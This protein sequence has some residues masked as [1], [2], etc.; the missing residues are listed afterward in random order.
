MMH[1]IRLGLTFPAHSLLIKDVN[2]YLSCISFN[3]VLRK[4]L[5]RISQC[6]TKVKNESFEIERDLLK[7]GNARAHAQG[8]KEVIE[9]LEKNGINDFIEYLPSRFLRRTSIASPG[10]VI[11][12]SAAKS[13]CDMIVDDLKANATFIAEM[14]PALGKL[15]KCLID[16]GIP[17]IHLYEPYL[18]FITYLKTLDNKYQDKI[19]I[20]QYNLYCLWNM[21]VNDMH[22]E[23]DKIKNTFEGVQ[24]KQY[25]EE[26]SMHIIC[27][28]PSIRFIKQLMIF[29]ILKN[30]IMLYGRPVFYIGMAPSLFKYL[31]ATCSDGYFYYRT[32]SILFQTFFHY[33]QLGTIPRSAILPLPSKLN[34]LKR[35]KKSKDLIQADNKDVVIVRIEPKANLYT[36]ILEE[37]TAIP[38]WFFIQQTTLSRST[39]VIP[40][41]ED[42]IPN[43]GTLF[44][45]KGIDIFTEFGHLEPM[46]LLEI[47]KNFRKLPDMERSSFY[48]SLELYMSKF[49]DYYGTHSL[50]VPGIE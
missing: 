33:Q 16:A 40:K 7:I 23:G 27:M 1:W 6:C 14:N 28:L 2:W 44:I 5:H 41:L 47:Y 22:S 37:T 12:D 36:E 38:F 17:K 11:D 30:N 15:T 18:S 24:K 39:R 3:T 45:P 34:S 26:P 20:R 31:S 29:L 43:C 13:I 19:D 9:C 4:N 21:G 32:S 46:Q 10:I 25:E 35:T 48:S 42:W 50:T 8:S 49:Y